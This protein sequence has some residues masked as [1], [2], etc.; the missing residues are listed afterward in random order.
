MCSFFFLGSLS[1]FSPRQSDMYFNWREE[2]V[3][4]N[5][6]KRELQ[7]EEVSDDSFGLEFTLACSPAVYFVVSI[8]L[9]SA[10]V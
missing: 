4:N 3:F 7:E 9:S 1:V 8:G 10:R 5:N 6:N 2:L